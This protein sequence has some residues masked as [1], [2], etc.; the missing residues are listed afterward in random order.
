VREAAGVDVPQAEVVVTADLAA[1][2][3]E[4]AARFVDAAR[5]AVA[6]RGRFVVALSGGSTP[7]GTYERLRAAEVD[8]S[9]VHVFFGDERGVPADHPDSNYRM[10]AEALLRH[11]PVP[12]AQVHRMPA[13][14]ADGDAAADA[15]A[16]EIRALLGDAP[17]FNL[18]MLGLGPEAHTASLFPGSAAL[19]ERARWVLCYTVDAAHGQR[20][21]FTPPLLSAARRAMFLVAGSDKAAAVA[22]VLRG[23][24]DPDRYP[25]QSVT[26]PALW[27]L[28]RAAA[29]GLQTG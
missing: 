1:A 18:V 21:T 20:M 13:E 8:W 4:A 28:D 3:A 15:Y 6:D 7:R 16:G 11:V 23:P 14:A 22:A 27:I 25:A 12:G 10:A 24:R 17:H 19:R 2:Q 5:Q 9:A 26:A 29:T